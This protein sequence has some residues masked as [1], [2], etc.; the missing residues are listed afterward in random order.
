[1]KIQKTGKAHSSASEEAGPLE[2]TGGK[3]LE[4]GRILV[5][6]DFS[7][8][9]LEALEFA[10]PL[11]QRYGGKIFLVH[12]VEPEY[13]VPPYPAAIT[14]P[15]AMETPPI[16]TLPST[17]E[18]GEKLAELAAKLVP[19]DLLGRTVVRTGRAYVEIVQAADE[20]GAGLIALTTHGYTGLKHVLLG[21]TAEHVVR[22]AHCAVLT[23]RQ[24]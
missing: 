23:V 14:Y 13:S 16:P 22:H 12:V 17:G 11:A 8:K 5:P 15:G 2:G 4:I 18:S 10:V 21:S 3:S 7:P 1:M 24:H 9:S 6:L 19:S 20:L